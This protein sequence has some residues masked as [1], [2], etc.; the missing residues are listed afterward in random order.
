MLR[1]LS[2]VLATSAALPAL[3]SS[4]VTL[5]DRASVLYAAAHAGTGI[6][7]ASVPCDDASDIDCQAAGS[8][9]STTAI[10]GLGPQTLSIA[11]SGADTDT[12]LLWYAAL[13]T[14][15]ATTQTYSFEALAGD[16]V[17]HASGSHASTLWSETID[18]SGVHGPGT[19]G[20]TSLNWQA[21]TFSL[22]ATTAYTLGGYTYGEYQPIELLRDD[23]SGN[24]HHLSPVGP[25][26]GGTPETPCSRDGTLDAGTYMVRVYEFWQS[27]FQDA[28]A[29]G[30]DYRFTFHDAVA[31][32][33][34][35]GPATLLLAGLGVIGVW[36]RRRHD[37]RA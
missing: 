34:E 19:R 3:A 15:W 10:T 28:Y 2:F 22:D 24:F 1:P 7:D 30:W 37:A 33:P 21:F 8:F 29:Y 25:W 20:F 13:E 6:A 5:L 35:P 4:T 17:L 11:G 12:A 18:A 27:D 32:V 26:C 14:T 9:G 23:G 16:A 36:R 31:A